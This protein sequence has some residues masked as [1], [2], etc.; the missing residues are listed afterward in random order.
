[1][2]A[3]TQIWVLCKKQY[4]FFTS[5]LLLQPPC[6]DDFL[7]PFSSSSLF[8]NDSDTTLNWA[9]S[10]AQS[11]ETSLTSDSSY[12]AGAPGHSHLLSANYRFEG[13]LSPLGFSLHYQYTQILKSHLLSVLLQDKDV[14]VSSQERR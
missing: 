6:N 2:F 7:F 13:V 8:Y 5:K 14:N 4:I 10:E 9:S 12:K 1:M 3:E 11:S